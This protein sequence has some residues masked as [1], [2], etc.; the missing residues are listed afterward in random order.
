MS[1]PERRNSVHR[2]QNESKFDEQKT[3]LK[4]R[5]KDEFSEK[6]TPLIKELKKQL[7]GYFSGKRKD[8]DLPIQMSGTEFQKSVWNQLLTIPLGETR[9]Y[10]QQ[11]EIIGNPKA[12]RA[13]ANANGDNLISIVIPCH[14]VIGANGS[15]TGYG[16]GLDNKQ[17]LLN[18]ENKFNK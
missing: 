2:I 3:K 15:L 18:H 4:K 14:R 17:W 1:A 16:G 8:F 9:S 5:L 7:D 11:A 10:K 13:V 6:E 12:V